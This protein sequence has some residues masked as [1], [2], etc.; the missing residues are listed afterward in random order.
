MIISN[1]TAATSILSFDFIVFL[2]YGNSFLHNVTG[3]PRRADAEPDHTPSSVSD[4]P[5]CSLS[6]SNSGWA[7]IKQKGDDGTFIRVIRVS[8]TTGYEALSN[9]VGVMEVQ[10]HHPMGKFILGLD[11]A[12]SY[13]RLVSVNLS[14]VP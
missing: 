10:F 11:D 12:Q 9:R 8:A 13:L 2:S 5:A 6:S 7:E 14:S 4:A 1:A 3:H